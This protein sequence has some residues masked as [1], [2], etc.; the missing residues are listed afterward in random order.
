MAA[1]NLRYGGA[2]K[3]FRSKSFTT[4]DREENRDQKGNDALIEK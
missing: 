4:E 2:G 3:K 1:V